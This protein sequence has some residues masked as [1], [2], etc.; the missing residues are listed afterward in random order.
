VFGVETIHL[1][2]PA[3]VGALSRR[4]HDSGVPITP[5][6]AADFARALTLVRPIT[7]RQLYWTARAVFVSDPAQ[8]ATFD[9]VFYSVFGDRAQGED[10]ASRRGADRHL[11]AGRAAHIRAQGLTPGH[12]R[13]GSGRERVIVGAQ[14][15]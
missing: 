5:A 1:D 7:R 6:R 15:A 11:A 4:L 14:R 3:L 9:A 12:G 13:A 10:F 2:L 8:V